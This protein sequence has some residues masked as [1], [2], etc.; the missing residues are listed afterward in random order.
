MHPLSFCFSVRGRSGRK[1][2]ERETRES[3]RKRRDGRRTGEKERRKGEAEVPRHNEGSECCKTACVSVTIRSAPTRNDNC[4]IFPSH[5]PRSGRPVFLS[6]SP[7]IV[8]TSFG[9]TD[10][11]CGSY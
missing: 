4:P 2:R 7:F 10:W 11:Y 8:S 6:S 5:V 1:E 3:P 9:R